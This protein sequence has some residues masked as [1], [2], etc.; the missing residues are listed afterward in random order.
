MSECLTSRFVGAMERGRGLVP[1]APEAH[2]ARVH[3]PENFALRPWHVLCGAAGVAVVFG[4][5]GFLAC[6]AREREAREPPVVQPRGSSLSR[7]RQRQLARKLEVQA[8]RVSPAPGP[9]YRELLAAVPEEGEAP[10]AAEDDPNFTP[11]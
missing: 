1:S 4:L 6:L 11:L 10:K 8:P 7:Y 3:L 5:L 2:A 9:Q